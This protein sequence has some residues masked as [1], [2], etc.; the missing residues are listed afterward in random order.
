MTKTGDGRGERQK[1]LAAWVT[2]DEMAVVQAA[3]FIERLTV[4]ALL[5]RVMLDAAEAI[6]AARGKKGR[7]PAARRA[8]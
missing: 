7:Q 5:R 2:P 4:S 8:P 3:A 6:V 1:Y